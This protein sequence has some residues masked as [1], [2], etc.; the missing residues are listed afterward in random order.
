MISGLDLG[1]GPQPP[2]REPAAPPGRV[3]WL[4]VYATLILIAVLAVLDEPVRALLRY[5]RTGLAA[6]EYWRL[7]G[8]HLVHLD[9][10]H[11][12]LNGAALWLLMVAIGRGVSARDWLMIVAGAMLGVDAG[13]YWLVPQLEWYVGLSGILHGALAGPALLL[14]L[15]ARLSGFL[16][17][18]LIAAKL[19]WEQWLGPLPGTGDLISGAVV[20]EAHLFGALGGMAGALVAWIARRARSV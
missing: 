6:G 15:Q 5:E 9:L 20:T 2:I 16:L 8:A 10:V 11:A 13:L 1:Q 4:A 3:I 14:C 17:L 7:V 12:V 19:G 18:L